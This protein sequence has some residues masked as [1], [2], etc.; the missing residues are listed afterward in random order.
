MLYDICVEIFIHVCLLETE[1]NSQPMT[2]METG[3]QSY[4]V[5]LNLAATCLTLKVY[6]PHQSLQKQTQPSR[7]LDFALGDCK[8]CP[9]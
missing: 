6:S 7:Y 1:S 3:P 2:S 9:S 4:S 5:E 8:P